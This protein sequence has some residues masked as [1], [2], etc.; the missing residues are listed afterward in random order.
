MFRA[1]VLAVLSVHMTK[2]KIKKTF[3]IE[4]NDKAS[5]WKGS[6]NE[7]SST[8]DNNDNDGDG[9]DYIKGEFL[10]V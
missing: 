3:L 1:V 6:S 2:S 9:E 10:L 8:Y 7:T 4:T 5:N